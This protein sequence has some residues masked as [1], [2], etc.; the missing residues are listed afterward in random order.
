MVAA[1]AN[2]N[3]TVRTSE[4]STGPCAATL[5]PKLAPFNPSGDFVVE[6]ALQFLTSCSEET[7]SSTTSST[8][9]SEETSSSNLR[10]IFV[11]LGCGDGRV[12]GAIPI[13]SSSSATRS[14]TS[15]ATTSKTK[16]IHAA[17][18][19]EYDQAVFERGRRRFCPISTSL[20]DPRTEENSSATT[21]SGRGA[22]PSSCVGSFTSCRK[23]TS[24][25]PSEIASLFQPE[26]REQIR[27]WFLI[28]TEEEEDA[29]D[30][31]AKNEDYTTSTSTST[32][33]TR[34]VLLADATAFR[35]LVEHLG[36]LFF[37]YLV[38]EGLK[39]IQPLLKRAMQTRRGVKVVSYIF[40]LPLEDGGRGQEGSGAGALEPT[41]IVKHKGVNIYCYDGDAIFPEKI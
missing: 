23:E 13:S 25:L 41:K 32:I 5:G 2:T 27:D 19:I 8:A 37:V 39:L 33:K 22:T 11:D 16:K 12:V 36:T 20:P 34:I 1:P 15:S 21:T 3:T 29:K 10:E 6:A 4:V 7:S 40:K 9:C 18:G 30:T 31:K 26:E 17:I 35:H 24:S 14:R 38:P 28:K